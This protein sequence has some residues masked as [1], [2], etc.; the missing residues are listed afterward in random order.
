MPGHGRRHAHVGRVGGGVERVVRERRP[1]RPGGLARGGAG[2][3]HRHGVGRAVQRDGGGAL[4]DTAVVRRLGLQEAVVGRD[5]LDGDAAHPRAGGVVV[6]RGAR[7]VG[8]IGLEA[9]DLDRGGVLGRR[10]RDRHRLG[11]RA[12]PDREGVTDGL[13]LAQRRH[14]EL[15]VAWYPLARPEVRVVSPVGRTRAPPAV[16]VPVLAGVGR[17]HVVE[18]R[19]PAHEHRVVHEQVPRQGVGGHEVDA[20]AVVPERRWGWESSSTPVCRSRR[21]TGSRTAGSVWS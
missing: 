18:A 1:R 20:L 17:L 6:H 5:G 21:R 14:A 9:R 10:R 3:V 8:G 19:A 7:G 15:G 13:G 2:A 4:V 16:L 11:R 12:R